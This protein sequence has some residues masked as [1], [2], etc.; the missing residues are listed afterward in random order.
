[1]KKKTTIQVLASIV[2]AKEA[3]RKVLLKELDELDHSLQIIRE[4][5]GEVEMSDDRIITTPQIGTMGEELTTFL[6][7]ILSDEGPT[8]RTELLEQVTRQGIV[9]GGRDQL[10]QMSAYMS[11]DDRFLADGRGIWRLAEG[12]GYTGE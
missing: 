8:H 9:I 6:V 4:S 12:V 10:S 2:A 11:R 5:I 1:M 3:R 7:A